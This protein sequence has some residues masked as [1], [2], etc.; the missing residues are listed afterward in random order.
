MEIVL[1]GQLE[2]SYIR[3]ITASIFPERLD[4]QHPY[5]VSLYRTAPKTVFDRAATF[6]AISTKALLPTV[7]WGAGN[8]NGS[9]TPSKEQFGLFE[10][11]LP[12]PDLYNE[13]EV[14]ADALL[15]ANALSDQSYKLVS[16]VG[17]LSN[18]LTKYRTFKYSECGPV[19]AFARDRLV[20]LL[21]QLEV[22]AKTGGHLILTAPDQL[23]LEEISRFVETNRLPTP[24]DLPKFDSV[25]LADEKNIV[26]AVLNFSP[27]DALSIVAV[28]ADRTIQKY[29]QLVGDILSKG[30]SRDSS[31]LLV[32]GMRE[33]LLKSETARKVETVFEVESWMMKPLHFI[34][35]LGHVFST[36]SILTE[37]GNKWARRKQT[38]T[39]WHMLGPKMNEIALKDYLMRM[40]NV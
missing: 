23:L 29:A 21:I 35:I 34:P 25:F 2:S 32:R 18:E 5:Y 38:V 24:V 40:D 12:N 3:E 27:P 16:D 37:L 20:R 10:T 9:D 14:F 4:T 13:I 11:S 39:G 1:G 22:S 28:R 7:D 15:T 33:A 31:Y 26:G 17:H 6:A 19:D 30:A 36:I 8:L